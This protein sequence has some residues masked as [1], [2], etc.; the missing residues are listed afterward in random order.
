[1]IFCR[2]LHII[3]TQIEISVQRLELPVKMLV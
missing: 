1:M 2:K 3:K